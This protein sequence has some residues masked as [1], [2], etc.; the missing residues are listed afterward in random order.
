MEVFSGTLLAHGSWNLL[1]TWAQYQFLL[2]SYRV[3][4]LLSPMPRRRI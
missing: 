1:E 2:L 4:L 3:F